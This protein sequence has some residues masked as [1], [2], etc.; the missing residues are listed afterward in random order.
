MQATHSDLLFH[1]IYKEEIIRTNLGKPDT[2][3][4]SR[5]SRFPGIVLVPSSTAGPKNGLRAPPRKRT[6]ALHL[7]GLYPLASLRTLKLSSDCVTAKEKCLLETEYCRLRGGP[8]FSSGEQ[9]LHTADNK[10]KLV[11][12][13]QWGFQSVEVWLVEIFELWALSV[14][15]VWSWL[16][17]VLGSSA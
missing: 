12:L 8:T 9:C 17:W 5:A 2:K 15:E 6:R 16:I 10:F 13:C 7:C 4:S 14:L 11:I 1:S 3:I